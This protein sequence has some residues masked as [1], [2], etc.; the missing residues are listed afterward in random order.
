ML[1]RTPENFELWKEMLPAFLGCN[2]STRWNRQHT[3][4][5]CRS[6]RHRRPRLHPHQAASRV[7]TA[8]F[9]S[10][11]LC[12]PCFGWRWRCVAV[13]RCLWRYCGRMCCRCGVVCGAREVTTTPICSVGVSGIRR[14]VGSPMVRAAWFCLYL[15]GEE[16]EWIW[17]CRSVWYSC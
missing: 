2:Q 12:R 11:P 7:C 17:R 6:P 5:P 13:S 1:Q 14:T 10:P 3:L 4:L 16:G 9:H 15:W 8:C